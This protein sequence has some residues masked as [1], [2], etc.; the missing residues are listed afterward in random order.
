MV[1][2]FLIALLIV[3]GKTLTDMA[4]VNNLNTVAAFFSTIITFRTQ[5]G[6]HDQEI[7]TVIS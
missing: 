3:K 2:C 6:K 4:F 1:K 7:L 5:S